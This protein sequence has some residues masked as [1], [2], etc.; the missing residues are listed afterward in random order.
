MLQAVGTSAVRPARW[1]AHV[2]RRD[3]HLVAFDVTRIEDAVARAAREVNRDDPR[4]AAD[5]A[6][7]VASELGNRFAGRPPAVEQI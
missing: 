1:P 4:L 6:A 2:R 5:L 7:A 3:G